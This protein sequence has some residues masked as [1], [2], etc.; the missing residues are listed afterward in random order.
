MPVHWQT[1]IEAWE[2][3][4]HFVDVEVKGPYRLW[5]HTHTFAADGDDATG[6]GDRVH[7][8]MPLGPL[9]LTAY[10]LFVRH[11]VERIFDYRSQAVA[12][13]MAAAS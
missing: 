1:R 10:R 5:E 6:I 8:A 3:P 7:Y 4:V 9:G 11:D 12:A 2:P 13:R